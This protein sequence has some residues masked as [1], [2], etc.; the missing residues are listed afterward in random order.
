M[1]Y[2]PL[3]LLLSIAMTFSSCQREEISSANCNRLR[4]AL[5][6]KN[7]DQ[8]NKAVAE[9]LITYSKE[10]IEELL[11]HISDKCGVSATL[12]CFEC[13]KTN[14]PQ[15]EVRFSFSQSGATVERVIDL[16][17]TSNHKIRVVNVHD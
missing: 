3:F 15:S 6:S 10:N 2:F 5:V 16:S 14:P 11:E 1:K 13:I 8:V 12:L 4:E 17:Y 9:L 7:V